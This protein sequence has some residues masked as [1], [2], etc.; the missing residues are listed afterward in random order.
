MKARVRV[1]GAVLAVPTLI[2]RKRD[3]G[4]LT[5]GE[6]QA[7]IAGAAAGTV[8]EYQLSALLMAVVWHGLDARELATWT[9]AMIASGDR[10]SLG[11]VRGRKVDKHSTGGVGDK[12]SL[13][14]APLVAACGVP[15]PMMSGR[16]LGH[17]GGTL[18]KLEAIPGF[19]TA[20]APAQFRRVLARA[21]LVLAGQSAR[22]VPADR[23]LYALRDATATVESIPL[24]ASSILSKKVAEGADALV[25][26]VKVGRG[27]FLPSRAHAR[28]LARTLVTLGGHLGLEVRALLTAM[29]EPLGLEIGNAN[30]LHEAIDVLRGGGP[31]DVRALTLR[32]GA[33]ML[34][35]G[36]RAKTRA[37]AEARLERAIASGDGLERLALCVRLHG[38]DPR[39]VDDPDR[40]PRARR[41]HAIRAA[42]PGVVAL[43]D[44]GALGRAATLLGAGRLRKEDRVDPGVGLTLHA[45][46]GAR[47][48]RGEIL[49]T[50]RYT[51]ARRL[52]AALPLMAAAFRVGTRAPAALPLVL[53]T[54]Q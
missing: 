17:T 25:M 7:L 47:V 43:V 41:A 10:M 33:E 2:A 46:Q 37:E 13:C 38:G 6:I 22:L 23:L 50:V 28:E 52:G 29:D 19:R 39:V 21:G 31:P 26:D 18:D 14:L 34:L 8:P 30:E 1:R 11:G 49:C 24:I 44:A 16:G 45:K 3:G 15:V 12:I 20:L 5:D 54:I 42:R 40:L 9:R 27:A 32:L 36:R 53:E 4:A 35:L 48:S 51:D